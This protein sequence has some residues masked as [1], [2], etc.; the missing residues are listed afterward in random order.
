M[1]FSLLVRYGENRLSLINFDVL[2]L[3]INFQSRFPLTNSV[4]FR[5]MFGIFTLQLTHT[6]QF[7]LNVSPS[8]LEV[9]SCPSVRINS[10]QYYP[11]QS[12]PIF[13]SSHI[14]KVVSSG[15]GWRPLFPYCRIKAGNHLN[16]TTL[17]QGSPRTCLNI[18]LVL[19]TS[20]GLLTPLLEQGS[21]EARSF[22]PL[23]HIDLRSLFLITVD[24]RLC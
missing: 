11:R 5:Y 12:S 8:R 9:E 6:W 22:P 20:V 7:P 15:L 3:L 21:K 14:G 17:R 10:T 16:S 23:G 19:P 4:W 24:Y 2:L 13:F 1:W 18:Y